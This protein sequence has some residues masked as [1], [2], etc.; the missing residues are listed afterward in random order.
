MGPAYPGIDIG[1]HISLSTTLC[2][3]WRVWFHELVEW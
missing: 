3:V 1:V 2:V